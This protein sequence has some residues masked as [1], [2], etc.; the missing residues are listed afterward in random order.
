MQL[1]DSR[2]PDDRQPA[3][4]MDPLRLKQNACSLDFKPEMDFFCVLCLALMTMAFE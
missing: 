2:L 1:Y 3:P 4:S